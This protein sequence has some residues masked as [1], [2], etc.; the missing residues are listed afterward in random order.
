MFFCGMRQIVIWFALRGIKSHIVQI[1]FAQYWFANDRI[2]LTHW[3]TAKDTFF[4]EQFIRIK[5]FIFLLTL[6]HIKLYY[7]NYQLNCIRRWW[8]PSCLSPIL[9][10]LERPWYALGFSIRDRQLHRCRDFLLRMLR[11]ER[12][13]LSIRSHLYIII[14]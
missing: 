8:R 12:E 4:C 6:K 2:N 13:P 1:V 10:C 5:I 9:V 3:L 11:A 14:H 7:N